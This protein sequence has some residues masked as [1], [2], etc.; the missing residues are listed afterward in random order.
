MDIS[1]YIYYIIME[2]L[3]RYYGDIKLYL[4]YYYGSIQIYF[5]LNVECILRSI[6]LCLV[7]DPLNI[8]N[9]LNFFF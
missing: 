5:L 8:K 3:W 2:I 7:K 9:S 4:L 1:R 6:F